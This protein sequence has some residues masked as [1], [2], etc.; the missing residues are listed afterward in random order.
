M[1]NPENIKKHRF[2]KGQSGNPKGRPK[3]P[4]I[5]EALSKIL[6]GDED[7]E[8]ALD[9]IL[10]ALKSRA[11][12]GDVRAAKELLDRAY[13][14]SQAKIDVTSGGDKIASPIQWITPNED[15]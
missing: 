9:S 4:D 15:K 3:M 7:G 8:N 2:K 13:G 1:P 14:T 6:S 12:A 11:L 10:N 5:S